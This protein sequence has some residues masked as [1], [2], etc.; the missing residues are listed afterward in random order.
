L[1]H[2]DEARFP[3][4]DRLEAQFA[5]L[6]SDSPHPNTWVTR[7][8]VAI[9]A[10][11]LALA[12]GLG[13]VL[14]LG[15]SSS[16]PATALA[17]EKTPKWIT[18][19]LTDPTAPDTQM[20]QELADA[21]IDRVRVHSVPGPPRAVGTW[22]G[23]L[24]LGDRCQGGVTQFGYSV[25]IPP[26]TPFNHTNH[27]GGQHQIRVTLPQHTGAVIAPLTGTPFSKSRV[28]LI[29]DSV[30]DPRNAMKV[31]VPVRP[32]S[33]NDPPTAHDIGTD[34]LIALGGPFAQYGEAIQAGQTSCADLGLK[35]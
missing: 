30:D 20:N 7:P 8:R 22:A 19:T 25:D 33:P 29:T 24:E 23:F 26:S 18:L 11:I 17:I 28:R 6:A 10:V 3:S 4:L 15:N 13:V 35:P 12:S 34:Q 16:G 5:R 2:H 27:H 14:A 9:A 31:L 1:T 21:G 32:R